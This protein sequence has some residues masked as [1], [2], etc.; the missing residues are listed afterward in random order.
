M[1]AGSPLHLPTQQ[2]HN[3]TDPPLPTL[4][5]TKPHITTRKLIRRG[6]LVKSH[7]KPGK[8]CGNLVNGHMMVNT[9]KMRALNLERK[10]KRAGGL[11]SWLVS[12]G[13]GQFVNIFRC[14]RVGKLQLVNLTMKKLK[15][16]GA[17]A[18]GPRRKLMHAFDCLW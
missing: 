10:L 18:V 13:L 7:N 17:L 3:I 16:M 12:L 1:P 5:T 8:Y 11:N 2:V 9:T 6:K 14:K 15:D 4:V